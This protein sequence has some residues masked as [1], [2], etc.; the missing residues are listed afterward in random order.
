MVAVQIE[1]IR[2]AQDALELKLDNLGQSDNFIKNAA[3]R[4]TPATNKTRVQINES[5]GEAGDAIVAPIHRSLEGVGKY[6]GR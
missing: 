3:G 6:S 2:A 5:T 4:F 1:S